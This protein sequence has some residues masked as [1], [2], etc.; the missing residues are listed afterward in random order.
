VK[1]FVA[2]LALLLLACNDR[3]AE[4]APASETA[5]QKSFREVS[6]RTLEQLFALVPELGSALGD[7]TRDGE[8]WFPDAA[9]VRVAVAFAREAEELLGAFEP[10]QLSQQERVERAAWLQNLKGML[11]ALEVQRVHQREPRFYTDALDVAQ[12]V[13]KDYA[14]LA[15]RA[16][17]LAKHADAG[18]RV[19]ALAEQQLEPKL[20]HAGLEV[21][22]GMTRGGVSFLRGDI[23]LALEPLGEDPARADALAASERLAVAAEKYAAFLEAR[24]PA[25]DASYALGEPALLRMLRETE[26]L[27]L[28]SA[29]I[30]ATCRA[31][32]DR[33]SAALAEAAQ[34]I[35]AK[36]EVEA[37]VASVL[38]E[39]LPPA[40]VIPFARQKVEELRKLIVEKQLAS[41]PA[42][43][44]LIV[45]ES[46]AYMRQAFAFLSSGGPLEPR[47]VESHYYI[48]PPEPSWPPAKQ[49][50]FVMPTAT[51]LDVSAHEA[52]PGHFLHAIFGRRIEPRTLRALAGMGSILT[53]EGWGLY[54]EEIAWEAGD[55]NPRDRVGQLAESLLRG[56]RCLSSLGLHIKG[57]SVDD[58][59]R[60]FEEVAHQSPTSAREEA[61]RGT[62]DPMYLGYTLGKAGIR[63]LREDVRAKWEAEGRAFTPRA[64]HDAFLGYGGVPLPAIR[65]ALLASADAPAAS[66]QETA[67]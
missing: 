65:E 44:P 9:G 17:A 62:S 54:A 66:I 28:T 22:I 49:R 41:I 43:D 67:Q 23:P 64:F 38:S 45:T 3:G 46:P 37:V 16:R 11:F 18:V 48:T 52:F 47:A 58:A 31:E 63:Q 5:A 4:R 57:W 27:D 61:L 14:P 8:L 1:R 29:Q 12:F 34:Q 59:T 56:A 40:E 50:E 51:L 21:A 53:V 13:A 33:D 19:L 32:I 30:E 24:L 2:V 7:H 20:P 60:T 42:D 36:R 35:D 26:G 39:R 55:R 15:Q 10:A 6:D 25:A